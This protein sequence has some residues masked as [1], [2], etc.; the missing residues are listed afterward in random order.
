MVIEP[1]IAK[2]LSD[3]SPVLSFH[4]SIIIFVVFTRSGKLYGSFSVGKILQKTPVEELT[5]VIRVEP[6]ETER[7]RLLNAGNCL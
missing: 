3:M 2:I 6:T 7:K 1:T 5:A 4:M